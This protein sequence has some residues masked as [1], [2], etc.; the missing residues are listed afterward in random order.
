MHSIHNSLRCRENHL[1]VDHVV[2]LTIQ[3]NEAVCVYVAE[4][5]NRLQLDVQARVAIV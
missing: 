1:I 3:M 5:E 4:T 2:K